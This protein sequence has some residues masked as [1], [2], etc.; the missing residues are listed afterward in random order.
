MLIANARHDPNR[1]STIQSCHETKTQHVLLEPSTLSTLEQKH[2]LALL[3]VRSDPASQS[4]QHKAGTWVDQG[5]CLLPYL[6][7]VMLICKEGICHAC[8]TLK[9]VRVGQGGVQPTQHLSHVCIRQL[10]ASRSCLNQTHECT[11]SSMCS[12]MGLVNSRVYISMIV[13]VCSN[14]HTH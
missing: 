4:Q 3:A 8:H 10:Q 13:C 14:N 1:I 12:S 6:E 2:P 11:C 9:E 5:R 7:V